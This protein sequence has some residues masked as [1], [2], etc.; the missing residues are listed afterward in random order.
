MLDCI[1]CSFTSITNY[2]FILTEII[3]QSACDTNYAPLLVDLILYSYETDFIQGLLKKNEKNF[4]F[5]YIDDFLWLNNS[6]FCDFVDRIYPIEIEIMNTKN[7]ARS[8]SYLDLHLEIN[9]EGRLRTKLYDKK[10]DF[11]FPIGTFPF[12]CSNISAAP[13]YGVYIIQLI[14]YSRACGSCPDFLDIVLLLTR[15]TSAA[16]TVYPSGEPGFIP[17]F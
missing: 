2:L 10:E 11:N 7:T 15:L 8:A 4:T 1:S 13:A 9:S 12:I 14:R 3:G 17:A 6:M 5:R 16:G